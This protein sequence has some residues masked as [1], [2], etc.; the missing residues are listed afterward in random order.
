M[1]TSVT[2]GSVERVSGPVVVARGLE[3]ARMYDLVR[4]GDLRLIGEVIRLERDRATIQV[5]ED[6]S[7][8]RVGEPVVTTGLPLSVELGPGLLGSI[9]DGIQRPLPTM[10]ARYG[11]YV[12][13]AAMLPAL[14]R[15]RRWKFE[16]LV[17]PGDMVGPG[18]VLG[19][20][21]ETES[22]AHRV[23]VPPGQA[24]RVL[25]IGAG[26]YTV[27]DV[28]ALIGADKVDGAT[29]RQVPC[30]LAQAWPVRRPRPVRR[31]LDPTVPLVT[32]QRVVDTL[33]PI[34]KGGVA[35]IPGGF[36]TGKTVLQQTLAKW[37]DADIVVYVACGE[38]GNEV[39]D[40]L[41][42]FPHLVDQR[43]G[44]PLIER[45]VLIANTSNMPVAAR[46][47]SIYTG[48]TI[49]EYYRDMGLDVAIMAD[50]TSRWAEALREVSGR[51]EEM[52][53]EE[54]YPAYLASRL[55]DFYERS[56]RAVC[57]GSDERTGSVTMIGAVSPQGGDFSEPVTQHSLRI[58]GTFWGLDS[59]LAHRRHFPAISWTRS[60]SL[61]LPLLTDWYEREV[62]EGWRAARDR[63]M[64]ILQREIE[65]QEVVQVVGPD[66]LPE[67]EKALLEIGRAIRESF[68]Q[69]FALDPVDGYCPLSK[70]NAMLDALL[71]LQDALDQ[72]L[73]RGISLQ[74]V[75]ALPEVA[76]LPQMKRIPN[77]EAPAKIADLATRL[78]DRIA[79]LEA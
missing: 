39:T 1:L 37:S 52:P 42:S 19:Q 53:G 77:D 41:A 56:G 60:Y 8:L 22:L 49:A 28:V 59:D 61:Y 23:L 79:A 24:G 10:V 43:T 6:T 51:L 71:K 29:P 2:A 7:G 27:D 76:E 5:Y 32:G 50:S 54:G 26:E 30:R 75:M 11:D 18:D 72:A 13:R 58:A 40:V 17:R 34:A 15:A 78:I 63:A 44:R 36:G 66:A 33:F 65:L 57:L 12:P 31:K 25:E 70:Q 67:H 64:R 21:A 38:R 3:S 4:V 35:V 62:A 69:Q 73:A 16:P 48:L 14:D 45:T 46:E 55:A 47:A 68:L 9:F 20:V 74:A